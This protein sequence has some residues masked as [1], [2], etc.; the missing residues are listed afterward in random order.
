MPMST[1]A[2]AGYGIMN[3]MRDYNY[4]GGLRDCMRDLLRTFAEPTK[5]GSLRH[6]RDVVCNA[7]AFMEEQGLVPR[8]SDL[9]GLT[10][11]EYAH[12]LWRHGMGYRSAPGKEW[13]LEIA[14]DEAAV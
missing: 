2:T 9:Y 8:I 13:L 11:L 6:D 10:P 5:E 14:L 3:L 1:P 7:Y 4:H 12:R